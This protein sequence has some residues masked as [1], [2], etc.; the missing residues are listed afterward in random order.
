MQSKI[1]GM[2]ALGL[3]AG[4]AAANSVS[5]SPQGGTGADVNSVLPGPQLQFAD[6]IGG[7]AANE[8]ST[9]I[10]AGSFSHIGSP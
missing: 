10:G 9:S 2:L 6:T 4:P 7:G 5:L 3:L 8:L 1:L